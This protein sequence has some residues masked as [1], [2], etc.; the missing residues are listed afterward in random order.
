MRERACL[1][2][3]MSACLPVS[4][5]GTQTGM[6]EGRYVK[7]RYEITWRCEMRKDRTVIEC[8]RLR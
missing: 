7:F 6:G 8:Q 1:H 2:S 5:A 4:H 3:C